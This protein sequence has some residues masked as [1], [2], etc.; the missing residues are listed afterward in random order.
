MSDLYKKFV[1][2]GRTGIL[3][4][5]PDKIYINI[6]YFLRFKKRMN[7]KNPET[8]D[9]KLQWL[10]INNRNN[11]YSK[12][13][14][15]Y[16]AKNYVGNI[17]GKEY[18]I[19]TIGIY[20]KFD[21]IDFEKLPDK[22]VIKCTHDSG[23][24]VVVKDKSKLDIRK[25]RKKINKGLRNNGFNY[26]REWPYKN[27]KPRILIENYM[28]DSNDVLLDYKF[29]CFN[30]DCEY[31]LACTDRAI[32]ATKF[33]YFNRNWE[34]QKEMTNDGLKYGDTIKIDKPKNL[35]KMFE[36]ASILSKGIP[37]LRVDF[38]EANDKLYF[39]ELTFYPSSGFD[40]NRKEKTN[41]ILTS[42]LDIEKVRRELNEKNRICN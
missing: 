28:S 6:A 15:K 8:F 16:E 12:M 25:T 24:V 41:Q 5:I 18:I 13:V 3:N 27:V 36:F 37:F 23:S 7:W 39:G 2:I 42:K 19:P 33:F 32:G 14:D 21:D 34:I 20:D 35:D 26:G 9:E 10:K 29:Y 40:K 1:G 31:L 38:Y 11:A 17:I 22:F 30:G 4:W